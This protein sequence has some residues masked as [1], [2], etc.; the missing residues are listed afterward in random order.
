M[1][2]NYWFEFWVVDIGWDDGVAVG[3]FVV[4]KFWCYVFGDGGVKVFVIGY[5]FFGVFNCLFVV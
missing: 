2:D 4:D 1:A 5:V 3:D